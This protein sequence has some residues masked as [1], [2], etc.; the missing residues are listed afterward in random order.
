MRLRYFSAFLVCLFFLSVDVSQAAQ[1]GDPWDWVRNAG[2]SAG[3]NICASSSEQRECCRAFAI[4]GCYELYSPEY[5]SNWS[6]HLEP[7]TLYH[8][9]A[10][11]FM[12]G[13]LR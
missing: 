12:E 5:Q 11:A 8:M 3:E 1:D 6:W 7:G 9:C 2:E 4:E 10:K 13:C